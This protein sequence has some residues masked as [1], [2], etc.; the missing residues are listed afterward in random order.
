MKK[1]FRFIHIRKKHGNHHILV[2]ALLFTSV[3]LVTGSTSLAQ[4]IQAQDSPIGGNV[5]VSDNPGY[6]PAGAAQ[7]PGQY[8]NAG[9]QPIDIADI[10]GDDSEE[11]TAFD[12][13]TIPDAAPT[14]EA[15]WLFEVPIDVEGISEQVQ[16]L[17]IKCEVFRFERH[18][19]Y[20]SKN[21]FGDGKKKIDLQNGAY[22]GNVLIGINQSTREETNRAG[23]TR[24]IPL[25][26]LA[27]KY[28]C[29]MYL[30]GPDNNWHV[31]KKK[32]SVSPAFRRMSR[33][34]PFRWETG[35]VSIPPDARLSP[36]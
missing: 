12:P 3:V 21:V 8:Q 26:H 30:V 16:Q 2:F 33:E 25:G 14:P 20:Y 10:E 9:D 13:S 7:Q 18:G 5:Q 22:H 17:G 19:G 23:V 6:Q 28:T 34:R 15:D 32:R 11:L 24:Y 36:P 29:W 4:N 1:G 35:P 27:E 31:P